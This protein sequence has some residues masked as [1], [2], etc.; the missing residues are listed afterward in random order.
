MVLWFFGNN[1]F[2]LVLDLSMFLWLQATQSHKTTIDPQQINHKSHVFF[3]LK[4]YSLTLLCLWLSRVM[5]FVYN[6]SQERKKGTLIV[7]GS[8]V[9]ICINIKYITYSNTSRC[10]DT[11]LCHS[12]QRK[13]FLA[14]CSPR[15]SE[16]PSFINNM[17]YHKHKGLMSAFQFQQLYLV[18]KF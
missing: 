9:L 16:G 15:N 1:F 12:F 6:Q 18:Q 8:I 5:Y 2:I 4:M 7:E 3:S 11:I 17:Q 10:F 14:S 13:W